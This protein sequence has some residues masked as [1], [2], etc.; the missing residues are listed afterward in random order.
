M[1]HVLDG[2]P[3]L[4]RLQKRIEKYDRAH[5][6][7]PLATDM[8]LHQQSADEINRLTTEN[9]RLRKHIEGYRQVRDVPFL[10]NYAPHRNL[11]GSAQAVPTTE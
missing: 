5:R 2:R 3:L 9:Q 4:V 1:P 11:D 6:S 7:S 8:T 10:K